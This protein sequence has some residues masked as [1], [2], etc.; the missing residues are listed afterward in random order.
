MSIQ[1]NVPFTLQR[2]LIDLSWL[3]LVLLFKIYFNVFCEILEIEIK[4]NYLPYCMVHI[5]GSIMI[6]I[7]WYIHIHP[8]HTCI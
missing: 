2:S 4:I 6:H 3:F 5:Y 8:P 7:Y 1:T